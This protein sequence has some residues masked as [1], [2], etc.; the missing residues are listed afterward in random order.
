M[1]RKQHSILASLLIVIIVGIILVQERATRSFKNVAYGIDSS[2][3]IATRSHL[4]RDS[5][6]KAK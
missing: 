2:H 6:Q 5:L 1:V 4:L 3:T